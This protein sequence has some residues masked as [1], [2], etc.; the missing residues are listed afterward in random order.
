MGT[1]KKYSLH[2]TDDTRAATAAYQFEEILKKVKAAGG[3]IERDDTHPLYT[4]IGLQEGEIG[5]ERIVEFNLNQTDFRLVRKI[6]T[7]R[8]TG[9]GRHKSLEEM[10]P[11]RVRIHLQRKPELN[12][13]YVNVDLE[14][15]F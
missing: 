15:M 2:E 8:I 13:D 1:G 4:D 5:E 12:D 9:A 3:E 11:P 14:D 6:E 10:T 7:H